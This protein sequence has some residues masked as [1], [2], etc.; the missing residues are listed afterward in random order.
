[1][2]LPAALGG[3]GIAAS[4]FTDDP[5]LAALLLSLAGASTRTGQSGIQR[6]LVNRPDA[7]RQ[8]GE[9][10]IQ[11]RDVGGRAGSALGAGSIPW[12]LANE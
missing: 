10:V 4:Q 12:L 8:I 3:S 1:M 11:L 9:Q 5:V 2:L 7:M 6:A